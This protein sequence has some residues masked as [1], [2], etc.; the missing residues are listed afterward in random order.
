MSIDV[1]ALS[2]DIK[3]GSGSGLGT[4]SVFGNTLAG[5]MFDVT[6][7]TVNLMN[8][9]LSLAGFL[10]LTIPNLTVNLKNSESIKAVLKTLSC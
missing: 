5:I 3:S 10:T 8:I 1:D 6:Q 4:I 9:R 2:I 7:N